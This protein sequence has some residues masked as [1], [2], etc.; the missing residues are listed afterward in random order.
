MWVDATPAP[1]GQL[2]LESTAV[3]GRGTATLGLVIEPV[4]QQLGFFADEELIIDSVV[5]I[6]GFNSDE[7]GYREQ[8]LGDRVTIDPSYPFLHIDNENKLLFYEEKFYRFYEVNGNDYFFDH[9]VEVQKLSEDP[10]YGDEGEKYFIDWDDFIDEDEGVVSSDFSGNEYLGVLAYFAALTEL[11]VEVELYQPIDQVD[12]DV[13]TTTTRDGALSYSLSSGDS[14]FGGFLGPV[15]DAGVVNEY[16]IPIGAMGKTTGG[17]GLLGSNGPVVVG[18]DS[19][20]IYGDVVSGVG[21]EV[22]IETGGSVSGDTKA[23]MSEVELPTVEVP[24]I[25]TMLPLVEHDSA[26]PMV[27]SPGT[28]GYDRI[29]VASDAELIIRGPATVVIGELHLADGAEL[30]LDTQD[31][32]VE[33][34][35]TSMLNL[36]SGSIV[37]TPSQKAENVSVQVSANLP[38]DGMP[39]VRL[40]ANSQFYGTVYAPVAEVIVGQDFE[41]YGG[42]VAR[43]LDLQ[44]GA[45]L[46][47]D[48][49]GSN[50]L[51]ARR[52]VE[53]RR[54]SRRCSHK[55]GFVDRG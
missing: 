2:R 51:A 20:E 35:F 15:P 11:K 14:L 29:D 49:K 5:L 22:T 23:R 50:A 27:I 41:I 46:H 32:N 7:S 37:T 28:V 54:S 25:E 39:P 52:L 13:P 9:A 24:V 55:P 31:G 44:P 47:Y 38:V 18:G 26:L 33:L 53:D 45:K 1:D 36:G 6:D 34:F 4:E 17:G 16:V 30:T 8:V 21:E 12:A 42:V 10:L 40:S 3:C 19:V 48:A 43:I